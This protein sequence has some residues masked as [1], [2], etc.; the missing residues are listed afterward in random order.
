[1]AMS[2][3]MAMGFVYGD[4]V[5]LMLWELGFLG[6]SKIWHFLVSLFYSLFGPPWSLCLSSISLNALVQLA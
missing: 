4:D 2:M 5:K 1:M 3:A 6:Q